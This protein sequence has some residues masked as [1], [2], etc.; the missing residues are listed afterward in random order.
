MEKNHTLEF[1]TAVT[2]EIVCAFWRGNSESCTNYFAENISFTDE[3]GNTMPLQGFVKKMDEKRGGRMLSVEDMKLN[4]TADHDVYVVTGKYNT[5]EEGK[6][7]KSYRLYAVWLKHAG[8][9][10][11]IMDFL[12][13][14]DTMDF[15]VRS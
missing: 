14:A 10:L 6:T 12:L 5:A 11:T 13:Q 2:A 1:I 9:K 8:L 15:I 3:S 7:I 4:V